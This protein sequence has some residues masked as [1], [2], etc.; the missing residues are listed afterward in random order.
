MS[1]LSGFAGSSAGKINSCYSLMEMSGKKAGISGFCGTNTG[2][3]R[4]SFHS[5]RLG[6]MERGFGTGGE[7]ES[8][9]FFTSRSDAGKA[10]KLPD[11]SLWKEDTCVKSAED[12]RELGFDQEI[13]NYTGDSQVLA[14]RED[15]WYCEPDP[16]LRN[17]WI[18][19]GRGTKTGSMT[20]SRRRTMTRL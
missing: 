13:W 2:S 11:S 6:K 8:C 1:N 20:K 12:A 18:C 14:F 4:Q 9:L 3:I 7:M 5:G 16:H 15:S 10:A 19:P 17:L